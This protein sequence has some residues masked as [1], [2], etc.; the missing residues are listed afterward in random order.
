MI[1]S[2]RSRP[3]G[4]PVFLA[5]AAGLAVMTA[6][7]VA[8]AGDPIAA[9]R[10][11]IQ[12]TARTSLL[13]FLGAFLASSTARLWPGPASGWLLANRRW[14]GLGFAFSHLIHAGGILLLHDA[15]PVLFWQLTN[16]VSVVS[17]SIAYGMIALM[18]ATSID[19][20]AAAM[21][22]RAW[23]RLHTAG[24]WLL[25]VVFLVSNGKRIGN[26]LLYLVPVIILL[27]AL[28]V[29]MAARRH[30]RPAAG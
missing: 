24:L 21:G 3:G 8:L 10:L 1:I 20:V 22:G 16:P 12:W 14:L 25:W 17:G 18:A 29:R 28:A 15:D 23:A 4:A 26:S 13:L 2:D 11:V 6:G 30:A 27:A 5:I 9:M 19:R 7:L